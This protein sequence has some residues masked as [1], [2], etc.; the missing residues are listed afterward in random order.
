MGNVIFTT[1]SANN[2]IHVVGIIESANGSCE[3]LAVQQGPP[4][5]EFTILK[6]SN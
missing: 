6:L 3:L 5:V 1:A 4:L 2:I